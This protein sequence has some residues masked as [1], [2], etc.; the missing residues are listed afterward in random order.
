MQPVQSVPKQPA[1]S[2]RGE[3]ALGVGVDFKLYPAF[4]ECG[5]IPEPWEL[6]QRFRLDDEAPGLGPELLQANSSR[7]AGSASRTERKRDDILQT[8]RRTSSLSVA[9]LTKGRAFSPASIRQYS[10]ERTGRLDTV[11]APADDDT[12]KAQNDVFTSHVPKVRKCSPDK[13]AWEEDISMVIRSRVIRGYGLLNVRLII[14][15]TIWSL[16]INSQIGHNVTVVDDQVGDN[17]TLSGIWDWLR[18][19]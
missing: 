15:C 5:P 4:K 13:T 1:W 16:I 11:G 10:H 8:N 9:R 3:L 12:G 7:D 17:S 2:S 14:K 6:E 18:R 19:E